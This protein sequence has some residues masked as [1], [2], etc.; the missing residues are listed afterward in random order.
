MKQQTN[1]HHTLGHNAKTHINTQ[2][3]SAQ[4]KKRKKEEKKKKSGGFAKQ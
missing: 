4:H 2:Y 1:Q 3:N